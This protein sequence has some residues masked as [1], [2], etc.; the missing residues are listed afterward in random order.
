M[1]PRITAK[2]AEVE[3][4]RMGGTQ[5]SRSEFNSRSELIGSLLNGFVEII[6]VIRLKEGRKSQDIDCAVGVDL[7]V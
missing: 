3:G 7:N 5:K 6:D 4:P 2:R 1:V